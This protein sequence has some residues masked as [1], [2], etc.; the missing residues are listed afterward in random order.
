MGVKKFH[1]ETYTV[2][3]PFDR[4]EELI[5]AEKK[6]DMA[7]YALQSIGAENEHYVPVKETNRILNIMGEDVLAYQGEEK[8][9]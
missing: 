3:I 9:T 6:Y 2:E 7:V 5:L 4:Y 1:K 8:T